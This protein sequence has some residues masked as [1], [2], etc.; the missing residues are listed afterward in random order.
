MRTDS[1]PGVLR[2]RYFWAFLCVLA[3]VPLIVG[4]QSYIVHVLILCSIYAIL[5]ASWD[6]V[7]G[8]TG[9]ISFA[10]AGLFAVGAYTAALS[11][12][13]LGMPIWGGIAGGGIV[14]ASF[15]LLI[16]IPA[17]RLKGHY[18]AITTLAFSEIFRTVMLNA[19]NFS[20]GPFGVFDYPNFKRL[21]A[22]P[23]DSR[24]AAYYVVVVLMAVAILAMRWVG[25]HSASGIVL[26]AIRDDEIK[27]ESLG[28]D[29]KWFKIGAFTL[30]AFFAGVAGA[31]YAYYVGVVSPVISEVY[32]TAL[33]VTMVVVG[34][35]G[36]IWGG[37]IGAFLVYALYESLR[38][39]HPVYNLICVGLV[40]MLVVVFFPRGLYGGL[41]WSIRQGRLATH[42][43]SLA[44]VSRGGVDR[45]A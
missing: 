4:S 21:A 12:V 41:V 14:A 13:H 1:E 6:L 36:S 39:V 20:G 30:S 11:G 17:L 35:M 8:Y 37:V 5:A 23:A 18:L 22:S 7:S 9:Q 31:L 45:P 26:Q 15:G 24:L 33:V 2:N 43:R 29:V 34:G 28:Y 19:V 42:R 40:L 44:N 32:V 3:V 25:N 16:G 27:A 10:H 38:F